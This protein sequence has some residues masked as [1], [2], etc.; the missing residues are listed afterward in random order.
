MSILTFDDEI[1]KIIH[2]FDDLIL[3][4]CDLK[5]YETK[6]NILNTLRLNTQDFYFTQICDEMVL[7]FK[8][9]EQLCTF[10]YT[11]YTYNIEKKTITIKTKTDL[12]YEFDFS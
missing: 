4:Y 11:D 8:D 5:I 9:W 1:R 7:I 12:W 2:K 10:V 3:E 6:D